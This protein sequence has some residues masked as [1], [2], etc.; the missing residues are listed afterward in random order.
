MHT[1]CCPVEEWDNTEHSYT[2]QT[3]A[4]PFQGAKRFLVAGSY[5]CATSGGSDHIR[6]YEDTTDNNK[7]AFPENHDSQNMLRRVKPTGAEIKMVQSAIEELR[8]EAEAEIR[9]GLAAT[10]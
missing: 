6:A 10:A 5:G 9:D 4:I 2:A 1:E 7:D 8:N 3:L